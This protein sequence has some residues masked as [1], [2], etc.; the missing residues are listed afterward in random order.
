M[1]Q[2]HWT[3]AYRKI[4]AAGL[5]LLAVLLVCCAVALAIYLAGG[6]KSGEVSG[7][8]TTADDSQSLDSEAV[9]GSVSYFGDVI[10]PETPDAGQAYQDGLIFVG[11][12]LTA[13]LVDRGVLTGGKLT[14][15]VWRTQSYML[16][17]NSQVVSEKIILPATK[18]T[19]TVAEAAERVKPE[20]LI[21]T[22]G[23]DWGVA[24]LN[25]TDFKA[26]YTALV[27]DIQ[28]ASPRTTVILQSIFPITTDGET[29]RLTN[30]KINACNEWVKAVAA[31][32]GCPYLDTQSVL[33]G[34]DGALKPE[35]CSSSDGIHLTAEAYEVILTYIR[36]HA[37]T[38]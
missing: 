12:S 16:N 31:A 33:K 4:S 19:V 25:E 27:R 2:K 20:I 10:L 24:Y 3:D 7:G 29:A 15:Q 23:T 21:L 34:E 5:I 32:C 22:L 14:R 11:D 26:C 13:H 18:E 8:E 37:Y 9:Q 1:K 38:K 35:Y 6:G 17:L 30:E 36:T 28:K